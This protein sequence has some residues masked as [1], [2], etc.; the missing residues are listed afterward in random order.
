MYR[1]ITVL[2]FAFVSLFGCGSSYGSAQL[3]PGDQWLKMTTAMREQW[4]AQFV[5]GYNFAAHQI[6]DFVESDFQPDSSSLRAEVKRTQESPTQICLNKT[7]HFTR[8]N[9]AQ[10]DRE[11]QSYD[12]TITTFYIGNPEFREI[13]PLM[14]LLHLSDGRESTP[15]ELLLDVQK[16][17]I[18]R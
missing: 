12:S 7:Y 18:K 6:C 16:G 14:L 11:Y 15:E 10:P 1:V 9:H 3:R 5:A 13:P 8:V 17:I 4:T 2:S